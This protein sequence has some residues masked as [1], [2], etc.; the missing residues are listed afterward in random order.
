M[1]TYFIHQPFC[2]LHKIIASV[3]PNNI[4]N[5]LLK[6][7]YVGKDVKKNNIKYFCPKNFHPLFL[8]LVYI[9]NT[10]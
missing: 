7:G 1:K 6:D 10:R 8:L 3:S 5:N 9:G 4:L 2:I